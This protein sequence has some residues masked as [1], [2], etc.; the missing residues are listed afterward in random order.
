GKCTSIL[1]YLVKNDSIKYEDPGLLFLI[2]FLRESQENIKRTLLYKGQLPTGK[3]GNTKAPQWNHLVA[4][5]ETEVIRIE[6][7]YKQ[8][9]NLEQEL[10][11]LRK[12]V[13][14]LG[15]PPDYNHQLNC[16]EEPLE[17]VLEPAIEI[18]HPV[19]DIAETKTE[20]PEPMMDVTEKEPE[21]YS[22]ELVFQQAA[23]T[24]QQ[25][26]TVVNQK[27]AKSNLMDTAMELK[28]IVIDILE[29]GPD[30]VDTAI[31]M[32]Q[33]EILDQS[34]QQ[35]KTLDCQPHQLIRNYDSKIEDSYLTEV[36][37]KD[38]QFLLTPETIW[39]E[40]IN[41]P[42]SKIFN[43]HLFKPHL[44]QN[45]KY[46][47]KTLPQ[48]PRTTDVDPEA[49]KDNCISLYNPNIHSTDLKST[50]SQFLVNLNP[51]CPPAE[52]VFVTLP[53][54]VPPD[55]ISNPTYS[56]N[57]LKSEKELERSI[58]LPSQLKAQD[59]HFFLLFYL[60]K[61]L[62]FQLPLKIPPDRFGQLHTTFS[63]SGILVGI[64]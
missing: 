49:K 43:K 1:G 53:A 61:K 19:R 16:S 56:R 6:E 15:L 44:D 62:L 60:L 11:E 24:I 22:Q 48:E 3:D 54:P 35:I 10:I 46:I 55:I 47:T 33:E 34:V 5:T 26:A 18:K 31:G 59:K 7:R 40:D 37:Q 36:T 23:S 39:I 51:L 4:A 42:G 20:I 27:S 12:Q 64:G 13:E 9:H 38:T 52:E 45:E 2:P 30:S 50:N 63:R 29:F 57:K 14:A 58:N 17:H 21:N 25:P 8:L 28:H 41:Q 32:D